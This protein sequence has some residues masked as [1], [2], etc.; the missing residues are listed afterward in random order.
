MLHIQSYLEE[1]SL[2]T[3]KS[4]EQQRFNQF[5]NEVEKNDTIFT[6]PLKQKIRKINLPD[7][8]FYVYRLSKD[9]RVLIKLVNDDIYIL[10]I[11]T[12]DRMDQYFKKYMTS[13]DR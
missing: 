6:E 3:L 1:I 10:D 11:Y 2:K 7:S 12:H 4:S 9:K 13:V 8:N 5:K